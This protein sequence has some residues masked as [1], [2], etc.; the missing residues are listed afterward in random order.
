MIIFLFLLP[1]PLE[2]VSTCRPLCQAR[3]MMSVQPDP[4]HGPRIP[5]S[6]PK[7]PTQH[8]GSKAWLGSAKQTHAAVPSV[9][10]LP[11]SSLSLQQI[12]GGWGMKVCLLFL[13][14]YI[15]WH[16]LGLPAKNRRD[17]AAG[18]TKR[19]QRRVSLVTELSALQPRALRSFQQGC[20]SLTK[21][22][23]W[24]WTFSFLDCQ[25]VCIQ[26]RAL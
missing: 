6:G 25:F 8:N 18:I 2:D 23:A 19:W 24:P 11:P 10:C 17:L 7:C 21:N 1:K 12:K 26:Q 20:A 4:M 15:Q 3:S 13:L 5:I 14:H 16:C 22:R 9:S